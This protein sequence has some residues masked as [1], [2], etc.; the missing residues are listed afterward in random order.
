MSRIAVMAL[1]AILI[2]SNG[3]QA[4]EPPSYIGQRT[5][6]PED[7]RAIQKV[8]DDFQAA[9]K[10]KDEKLLSSLMAD[11]NLLW[12][13]PPPPAM[14]KQL[15][16]KFGPDFKGLP[17]PG[18]F[19]GFNHFIGSSKVP[20]EE[21]FYNIR[22]TQDANVAWVMFDYEFLEDNKPTNHG[23]ETWQLMK[24]DDGTWKIISVVWSLHLLN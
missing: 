13:S 14:F 11:E 15:R 18:M 21:R 5:A 3:A 8:I 20:V 24:W 1:A 4:A 19:K 12:V 22:I 17:P 9:I 23:V 6:T 16:Q 2:L 10:N 7:T